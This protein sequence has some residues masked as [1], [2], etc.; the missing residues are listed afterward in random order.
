MPIFLLFAFLSSAPIFKLKLKQYSPVKLR[1]TQTM[2]EL[3]GPGDDILAADL[4]SRSCSPETPQSSLQNATNF[5]D[6]VLARKHHGMAHVWASWKWEI[7][8]YILVLATPLIMVATLY[9]HAG[10]PVP[11]WPFR[12]TINSLL[13]IYSVAL[14]ASVGFLVASCIGQLQWAWFTTKRPMYDIVLYNK[15]NRSAWGSLT[16]L[17]NHHVKQPLTALGCMILILSAVIDP[18]IQQL[19]RPGDCIV[20]ISGQA[21]LPRTSYP[22][23]PGIGQVESDMMNAVNFGIAGT[24]VIEVDCATGNCT[25]SE[26]YGTV[27]WCSYCEDSSADLSFESFC[28][29]IDGEIVSWNPATPEDCPKKGNDRWV[30]VWR[31]IKA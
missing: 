24:N 20:V 4:T 23:L 28:S 18:F 1:P 26:T 10:Q 12:I 27:G 25:F 31:H 29:L 15:A 11:S 16:L 13:S 8:T 5:E 21:R 19:T 2:N 7:L 3:L 14:R 6:K 30:V 17:W 9:P 22:K